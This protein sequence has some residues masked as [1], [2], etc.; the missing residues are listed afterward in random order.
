MWNES[1]LHLSSAAE[2]RP[3]VTPVQNRPYFVKPFHGL[4]TSTLVDTSSAWVDWCRAESFGEPDTQYWYA[5]T[6]DIAARVFVVNGLGDLRSLIDRYP[7]PDREQQIYSRFM[8]YFDF[9]AMS[10]DY[11][12]LHLT[13]AGQHSTRFSEPSMYGWDCESTLWFRWCFIAVER[14]ALA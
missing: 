9:E 1:Q 6:P 7:H 14:F 13:E 3:I 2:L 10:R 8:G 5:L 4:W 11:D 12:A